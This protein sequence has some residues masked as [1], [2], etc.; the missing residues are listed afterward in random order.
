MFHPASNWR[1]GSKIR[2]VTNAEQ[3]NIRL[4]LANFIAI[5]RSTFL[6]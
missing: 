5:V 6:N 1:L 3:V 4:D 2:L